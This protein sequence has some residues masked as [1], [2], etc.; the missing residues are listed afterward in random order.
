MAVVGTTDAD[1][2]GVAVAEATL[3]VLC[4]AQTLEVSV[5]HDGHARAEHLTLLHAVHRTR[6]AT[7]ECPGPAQGGQQG[8][9]LPSV[10]RFLSTP[11]TTNSRLVIV[12]YCP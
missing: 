4:A 10:L 11:S 6:R 3:Q 1:G 9:G 8:Q 2:D 12:K 7:Q 5:D